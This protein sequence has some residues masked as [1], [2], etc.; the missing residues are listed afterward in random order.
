MDSDEQKRT[1][2]IVLVV[3]VVLGLIAGVLF[4]LFGLTLV[5]QAISFGITF[6]IL[7]LIILGL[8]IISIYL[9]IKLNWLRRD[10]K[11]C[12]KQNTN[13]IKEIEKYK[14]LINQENGKKP[15]ESKISQIRDI[16][17]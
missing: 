16:F 3:A 17:K 5:V 15:T 4:L 9:W 11:K 12:E 14:A 7:F 6:V 13:L 10:I 8:A 2:T 1:L